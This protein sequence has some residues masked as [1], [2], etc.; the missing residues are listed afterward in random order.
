M[1]VLSLLDRSGAVGRPSCLRLSRS[2][3]RGPSAWWSIVIATSLMLTAG[4]ATLVGQN[5]ARLILVRSIGAADGPLAFGTIGPVATRRDL[6]AV[7]DLTSCEIVL[8]DLRRATFVRRIG[9]CGRGPGEFS[10]ID[11]M[12]WRGDSLLVLNRPNTEIIVMRLDGVEARRI[13]ADVGPFVLFVHRLD[14]LDDTTLMLSLARFPSAN[15]RGVRDTDVHS[16]IALID[17]R[18]G[19]RLRYLLEDQDPRSLNNR[20]PMAR[21]SVACTPPGGKPGVLAVLSPW[22][23]HGLILGLPG[24]NVP[25]AEFASEVEGYGPQERSSGQWVPTGIRDVG[26]G[27][28]AVLFKWIKGEE[29]AQGHRRGRGYLEIRDYRGALLLRQS[30]AHAD[31]ALFGRVGAAYGDRFY[32]YTNTIFAYPMILEYRLEL[33]SR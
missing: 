16:L 5:Q 21:M 15:V 2:G 6:L 1:R 22:T 4:P 29:D 25:A 32:L 23:F 27:E 10:Q 28:R 33:A 26:C 17:A 19:R 31:S 30:L 3:P 9:G 11:A 13:R 20:A 8:Y 24:T 14:V 18:T 12:A 7:A